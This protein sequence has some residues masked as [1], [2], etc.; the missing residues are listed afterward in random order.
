MILNTV[1]CCYYPAEKDEGKFAPIVGFECRG[2]DPIEW[3][4]E[5]RFYP[6]IHYK[7]TVVKAKLHCALLLI[8]K[9]INETNLN[10]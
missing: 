9:G 4:P 1:P 5:V 8:S 2:L 6:K 7:Q 10:L 3:R